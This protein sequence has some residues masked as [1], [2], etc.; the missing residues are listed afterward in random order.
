VPPAVPAL[1]AASMRRTVRTLVPSGPRL[2][3]TTVRSIKP[4]KISA[5]LRVALSG[6]PKELPFSST[7]SVS[8]DTALLPFRL[9]R[10][11]GLRTLVTRSMSELPLSEE[12]A[13]TMAGAGVPG[14]VVS[15]VIVS[16]PPAVPTL[17]A[18]SVIFAV[19]TLL[20]S[21]PRSPLLTLIST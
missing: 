2:P 14:A 20:P 10:I 6:V 11:S 13:K 18:T 7:S 21:A 3:L 15:S 1:P 4:L 16:E 8:P 17:P 19:K 5:L 9:M 12:L